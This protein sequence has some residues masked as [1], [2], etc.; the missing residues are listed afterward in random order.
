MSDENEFLPRD[1][2]FEGL[3]KKARR[4]T[5]L[6]MIIISVISSVVVLGG[7]Y[8]LGSYVLQQTIEKETNAEMGWSSLQGANVESMGTQFNY[9]PFSATGTTEFV[10]NVE[11]VLIPWGERHDV[12]TMFGTSKRE[13]LSMS[14]PSKMGSIDD[15]RLPFYYEGQRV[16]EFYHPDVQYVKVYD[17]RFTLSKMNETTVAEMAFS[18]DQAYS[19]QEVQKLFPDHV[20]WYWVDTFTKKDVKEMS[21]QAMDKNMEETAVI[22]GFDVYGFPNSPRP[23]TDPSLPFISTLNM[24]KK[25][26]KYEREASNLYNDLTNNKKRKLT[27]DSLK[28]IGVVVTGKPSELKAYMKSSAVR[29]AILGATANKYE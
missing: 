9:T 7:L 6:K 12:Y 10:K 29:G 18:F 22:N 28:I 25:D 14:G 26:G 19:I 20:A 27:P 13:S 8:I 2:E 21:N 24:L 17:D 5:L 23:D 15:D 16:M 3:V 4:K 11:G 1:Y